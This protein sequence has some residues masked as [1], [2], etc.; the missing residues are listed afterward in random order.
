M[1]VQHKNAADGVSQVLERPGLG[2]LY[3]SSSKNINLQPHKA[4]KR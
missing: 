2:R 1:S 3:V 4:G